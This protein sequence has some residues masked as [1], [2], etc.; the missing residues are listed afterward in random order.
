MT[1]ILTWTIGT[2]S[3]KIIVEQPSNKS[4]ELNR[5]TVIYCFRSFFTTANGL[6]AIAFVLSSGLATAQQLITKPTLHS[7]GYRVQLSPGY[8]TDSTA[9]TEVR[10]RAI[11][12]DW[13]PGFP[14]ARLAVDEF[15]G[16]LFQL[17]AATNYELEVSVVDSFPVF[18][19]VILTAATS[20]LTVPDIQPLGNL[21]WVSPN[22]SGSVYS[23]TNPGHLPTLFASGLPCGTTV[24]MKGGN[25]ALDNLNLQLNT[26]CAETEPITI[27]AAPGESAVFDGGSYLNYTWNQGTGDT[28]I[29]WTNLPADLEYNALCLVD[30]ERMYPYAFLTPPTID[31]TYPSLWTLGF[32]LPGFYRNKQ[33]QVFIKTIDHKNINDSEVIFSKRFN[34]LT[35]N[36]N[37]KNVRLRIKGIHF[38]YYGRGLCSKD[39]LG[40]PIEC[41][42]SNTLRIVDASHVVVDNCTFDFCNFPVTFEGNCNDN[43][44]MNCQIKDGTGYW[45]HAAFKTSRDVTPW[46]FDP[47]CGTYGRYLENA[48]IHIAPNAGQETQGNIVWKNTVEGV[49]A[50]INLGN[51]NGSVMTENDVYENKVSWC[52]DGI[53]AVGGHRNAR[54]WRNE[55]SHCPVGTSLIFKE[56]KP[57]YI[58]RNVYHHLDQRQNYRDDPNF[59]DCNNIATHQ[60]WS[61]ALKLNAETETDPNDLIYFIHN[62]VHSNEPLAFNLYLWVPTWKSLQLRNNLF[63]S[64][65]ISNF[66]FD[67]VINQPKYSFESIGDNVV[68]A[69]TNVKGIV[70]PIHG[71]LNEC[72]EYDNIGDLESGLS[73]TTGSP[74]S[75]FENTLNELPHFVD[76]E[77]ENFRLLP[78]S[79]LINQGVF[80][81]G[82]NNQF[83]GMAPDIGAFELAD[84]I[85]S[86]QPVLLP[87]TSLVIFPN[88]STG[89]FF[90]QFN[91]SGGTAELQVCDI[92]G[93][94]LA[95]KQVSD[96]PP[97]KQTLGMNISTFKTGVYFLKIWSDEG[98]ATGRLI[99]M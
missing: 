12:Q 86:E 54:I 15:R 45:S 97:G 42:P 23:E 47:S 68:N 27:M 29:W 69:G 66:M 80:V 89:A 7:I 41:Y 13:Q 26:D 58:F 79:P 81:P 5:S 38:K 71:G 32:D 72:F 11:G 2:K 30:G 4:K 6:A 83:Q 49:V 90:V 76:P 63:Y 34:C 84:S 9:F 73:G 74:F 46:L 61:T 1:N 87:E 52:Y 94:L 17:D 77:N 55:V 8:D 67:G 70:R 78:T 36:G 19:K 16:S 85:V 56:Q 65:G 28:S 44:V 88:P 99:K 39:F 3:K 24:L 92:Q 75:F 62:T 96:L 33:N 51:P 22:G 43:I 31:P 40:N 98:I 60:S 25:Y 53:D 35:I 91:L 20:T 18:E 95:A 82:F 48:G 93:R 50:G 37:N 21:K 57:V 64:E 59:Q 14:A 10:Y